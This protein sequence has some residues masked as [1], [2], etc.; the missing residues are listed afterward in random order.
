MTKFFR[1]AV[2]LA[3]AVLMQTLTAQAQA[4][5]TFVSGVGDDANP[6]SR[7]APCKTFAGAIAK[8]TA[9]GEID[10]LDPG[11]FGSLTITK[12]ITIR[13]DGV[14]AGVLVA[15]TNGF[16]IA[17]GSTDVVQLYG[18]D[19]DGIGPLGASL[20]GVQFNSGGSL[21]VDHCSIYNFQ[22]ANGGGS[23]INFQPSAASALVVQDSTLTS[24]GSSGGSVVGGSGNILVQPQSGGSA[25]VQL[26]RVRLLDGFSAGL[27]LD[28]TIGGAGAIT[29]EVDQV[30]AAG[31]GIADFITYTPGGGTINMTINDSVASNSPGYGVKSNGAP[32]T[33]RLNRV[34]ITNNNEGLV[35]ANGGVLASYGNNAVSG[36]NV[37]GAPTTT[38]TAK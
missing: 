15:G 18:L 11:G 33:V 7:T 27:R 25:S 19:I 17:A 28:G 13:A 5:R 14:T 31:N 2:L 8:T 23:G 16:V 9:S 35:T 20:A 36:N 22:G 12:A 29:A 6:C 10:V 34:T 24:N 37:D 3:I 38:I 32:S 4:T 1:F 30:V 21:V 26:T